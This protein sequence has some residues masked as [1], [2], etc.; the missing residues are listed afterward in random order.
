MTFNQQSLKNIL[1]AIV[2]LIAIIFISHKLLNIRTKSLIK[3]KYTSTASEILFTTQS[4]I[5][6]KKE[7]ILF[8]AL[9][10]ANDPRYIDTIVSSTHTDFQLDKFSESLRLNTE[11]KNVWVQVSDSKGI[12][13]YRSWTNRHGDDLTK[14]R[15]DIV[16]MIRDPKII[17]TISTGLFDMTFKAMVPIFR[18]NK[19]IGTIEVISK[20]NSISRQLLENEFE[21]VL[22]VD[23]AYKDQ[24]K[25]PFTN[26][27]LDDYY[28]ANLNASE[29][30][31][32]YIKNFG[33]EKLIHG[34]NAYFIDHENNRF[35]TKY[36]Q[37]DLNGN[38]MGYFI[39]LY[40]LDNIELKY[41]YFFHNAILLLISLL[42][43]GIYLLLQ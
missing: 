7:S 14:V 18:D 34:N 39:L 43:I 2:L 26:I 16:Q 17:S 24:I 22:L 42:I 25:K 37:K 9:S 12:S 6:A 1:L 19:F 27:F 20:F 32:N 5:Q 28:V 21:L 29:S 40:P 36:I 10:L 8:I 4:Y 13:L 30:N 35:I 23:K 38:N 11:Y 33:I 3:E 15:K 41:I 31:R